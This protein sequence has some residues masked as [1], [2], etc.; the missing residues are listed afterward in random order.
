MTLTHAT[1]PSKTTVLVDLGGIFVHPPED[2]KFQTGD[3]TVALG[4][5]L[6]SSIWMEYEMGRL[7]EK[8]CFVQV[9]DL[10]GFKV[11]E[12]EALV[13]KLR[14]TLTYDSEMLSIFRAIRKIPGV[15]IGL[16]TSISEAE[17]HALRARWDDTFWSI[18]DH[19]F[20]SWQLGV[21]KPSLRF[22]RHVLRVTR[23]VPQR[24]FYID[25]RPENVLDA[26]S[27]G[28]RGTVGA[29]D[30][31]RTL[32]N[33]IGDPVERGIAFLRRNAG[34]LYSSTSEGDSIDEN[35]AQL[36]VLETMKDE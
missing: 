10:F 7:S 27:L 28:L 32:M 16:V 21:R 20:T 5:V 19:I 30:I 35:Y 8:E 24:T 15:E 25:D 12:M 11:D 13:L 2:H 34:K 22:Y 17:Y 29:L 33:F 1:E 4:R 23:S 36:L 31:S 3:T 18:F 6:S 14:E 9:S 26:L